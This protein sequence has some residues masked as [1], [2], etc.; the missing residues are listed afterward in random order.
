MWRWF[1]I[2][3]SMSPADK[4]LNRLRDFLL[5]FL[6]VCT[7]VLPC[8]TLMTI[9]VQC[10]HHKSF[11]FWKQSRK[12]LISYKNISVVCHE[13]DMLSFDHEWYVVAVFFFFSFF[14]VHVGGKKILQFICYHK[15]ILLFIILQLF[16]L[17]RGKQQ[18]ILSSN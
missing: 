12:C 7:I 1:P 6:V 2:C 18:K 15:T 8:S 16:F 9:K 10:R 3:R 17:T 13:I 5:F 14:W 4:R 11:F